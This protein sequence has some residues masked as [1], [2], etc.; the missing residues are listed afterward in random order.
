MSHTPEPWT[1]PTYNV[2]VEGD[3]RMSFDNISAAI[4]Y[5]ARKVYLS[6]TADAPIAKLKS[7]QPF[8]YAY[9]FKSVTITPTAAHVPEDRIAS[10][11]NACA[12]ISDPEA[13][14]KAAR[15]FI[16]QVRLEM[17]ML[18]PFIGG[19]YKQGVSALKDKSKAVLDA[20][21]GA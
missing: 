17:T 2:E 8:H 18:E 12:G 4:D 3:A 5:A 6:V 21:K 7:G 20:I 14:I 13:A 16:Q 9:G 1:L 10:C 15:E 11:V 19:V